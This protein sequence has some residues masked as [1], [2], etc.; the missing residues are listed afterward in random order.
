[1]AL[2]MAAVEALKRYAK[3]PTD[4]IWLPVILL[5]IFFNIGYAVL[6]TGAIG[7]A[8]TDAA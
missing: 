5:G 8:I 1:M 4:L 2:S 7:A 3:F 6:F